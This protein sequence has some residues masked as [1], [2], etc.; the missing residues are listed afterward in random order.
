MKLSWE[1]EA[2]DAAA[3]ARANSRLGVLQNQR[4]GETIVIANEF[5]DMRISKVHTRNGARLLIESPKS[6]QWITL[7]ALELEALTWQNETTLSAMVGKP[8]Q[9]L[10]ATE[11]AS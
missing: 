10:I 1:G 4:D 9:S 11:D 5:S 2:E 7:D 3:A 8:F 6:G